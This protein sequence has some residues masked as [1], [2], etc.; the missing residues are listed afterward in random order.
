[1]GEKKGLIGTAKIKS[2]TKKYK[3]SDFDIWALQ[4]TI[5]DR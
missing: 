1:V 4:N 5:D 2:N 3:Y